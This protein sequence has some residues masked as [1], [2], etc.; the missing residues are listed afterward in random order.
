MTAIWRLNMT[1]ERADAAAR[2]SGR[3][4]GLSCCVSAPAGSGKTELLT[5][6]FL[7]LLA[8]V[9]NPEEVLAITFTRKAVAEMRARIIAALRA[10]QFENDGEVAPHRLLTLQLARAVLLRDKAKGWHLLAQPG[11]LRIFT[12]DAFSAYLVRQMPITSGFGGAPSQEDNIEPLYRDAV[13]HLLANLSEDNQLADDIATVAKHLDCKLA[14]LET[15]LVDLLYRRDQWQGLYVHLHQDTAFDMLQGYLAGLVEDLLSGLRSRLSAH[16]GQL[17]ELIDYAAGKLLE[18]GKTAPATELLGIAQLPGVELDEVGVWQQLSWLLLT[19][20]G[21]WRKTVT[22]N[23]GFPAANAAEKDRKSMFVDLLTELKQREDLLNLL[24][25]LR[26]LPPCSYVDENWPLLQALLNVMRHL[27]AYLEL[28]FQRAQKVDF[29]A[30]SLRALDAL[31][32]LEAPS[33]LALRLDYQIQHILV[34]EFQDTSRVQHDLLSRLTAEWR[35]D[36]EARKTLFI[37]GDAMQSIYAFRNARVGLFMHTRKNGMAGLPL[38]SLALRTNFR[39]DKVIVDWVN[40]TFRQAFPPLEDLRLGA[41]CYIDASASGPCSSTADVKTFGYFD[42]LSKKVEAQKICELIAAARKQDAGGSIAILLRTRKQAEHILSALRAAGIRW[43]AAE[44]DKLSEQACVADLMTITRAMLNPADRIA[45]LALLRLPMC[46]LTLDDLLAVA[47]ASQQQTVLECLMDHANIGS[48]SADGVSRL[49]LL[50]K[51]LTDAWQSRQRKPLHYLVRGVWQA[52]AGDSVY[53]SAVEQDYCQTYFILL[54]KLALSDE[55]QC[56]PV[57]EDS[58]ERQYAE[59]AV[60]ASDAVQIMTIHKAKGLEFDTVLLPSLHQR[61]QSDAAELLNWFDP[62]DD[63]GRTGLLIGLYDQ[64]KSQ[65]KTLYSYVRFLKRRQQQLESVRLLYVACTRAVQRLYLFS[66]VKQQ[67][68]TGELLPA[69]NS[70]LASLIWPSLG[71][72]MQLLD[73]PGA[74]VATAPA[75]VINQLTRLARVTAVPSV[76]ENG[77]LHRY[78]G[79]EIENDPRVLQRGNRLEKI[80]GTVVHRNLQ[81]LVLDQ[82]KDWSIASLGAM[83]ARWSTQLRQLGLAADDLAVALNLVQQAISNT[84][85][86]T[87]A[88]W[89]FKSDYADSAAELALAT[90]TDNGSKRYVV[91]RTFLLADGTRWI[92]DYKTVLNEPAENSAEFLQAKSEIYAAQLYAYKRAF[93]QAGEDKIRLGLYFPLQKLFTEVFER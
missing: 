1:P 31:G 4:A 80:V 64:K 5:Q 44:L 13:D 73:D 79:A 76:G 68:K 83:R 17:C 42:T 57:I 69:G 75:L 2:E 46:G 56:W 8:R 74:D 21:E 81:Q 51:V 14:Q 28:S 49:S 15:L 7:T 32:D 92:I 39:S 22:V 33:E 11:R 60:A 86:D 52:L 27:L 19:D 71:S 58:I 36:P 66:G 12:F 89:I 16:A 63:D 10:A 91:D 59:S 65:E 34:D 45:W 29:S 48:L 38:A 77:L 24:L 40:S 20:K 35:T 61:A 87:S 37:V 90:H 78:R 53:C 23:Q 50:T 82:G 41:T 54:E 9:Q 30:I 67:P 88:S 25:E 62:V 70:N 3:D 26:E 84:L 43:Q 18:H 85:S 55:P 72:A 6:R 47:G 93:Q